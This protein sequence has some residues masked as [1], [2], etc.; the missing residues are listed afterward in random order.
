MDALLSRLGYQAL[1]MAM[2]SGIALT[3]TYAITQCSRLMKKVDDKNILADLR[4]LR[5]QLDSKITVDLI[6]F[7]SGRGNAFLE[8]AVPLARAL[9]A[10][11]TSLGKDLEEAAAAAERSHNDTTPDQQ[12]QQFK[13]V[14]ADIKD[15]LARIDRDIP[16]LH[17]AITASGE[18]TPTRASDAENPNRSW[19][20][21]GHL[22]PEWLAFEVFIDDDEADEEA[23]SD[24]S[25]VNDET[26]RS[27]NSNDELYPKPRIAQ[28]RSSID[29]KLLEQLKT[30]SVGSSP[31]STRE[32]QTQQ[33]ARN[34]VA[35]SPFGAITT[36]L[37]LMEMLIRLTSLQEFQQ[38][39]HLS[40]DDHILTFFLE[41]TST[42]GLDREERWTARNEAKR[43][44][45]FD[46]YTDTPT[47]S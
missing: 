34:F 19:S 38:A 40:I 29:A 3:S 31:S 8:S 14:V 22:D 25:I 4:K 39:S 46:P 1:N 9:H 11:I 10:D 24:S 30:I 5:K 41:E 18:T 23:S 35:R 43:R 20:L 47:K 13:Q 45:G 32:I 28:D 26:E 12:Y 44:V 33:S 36:S 6:E 16:L 2:R 17:M 7:K 37:S 27:P 21:P 42:T 15:L